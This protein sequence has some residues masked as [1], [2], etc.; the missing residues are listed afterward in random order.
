MPPSLRTTVSSENEY[1]SRRKPKQVGEE[2]RKGD[3]YRSLRSPYPNPF[4]APINQLASY[5]WL[6][7]MAFLG[8]LRCIGTDQR[9][10]K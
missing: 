5:I 8:G 2:G 9:S 4:I 10:A 1:K 7:V 3:T 6:N